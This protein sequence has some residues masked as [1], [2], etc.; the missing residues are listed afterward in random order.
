ML[1]AALWIWDWR[2]IMGRDILI[3]HFKRNP[4]RPE[5]AKKWE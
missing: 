3:G 4:E 2:D 1:Q 5:L